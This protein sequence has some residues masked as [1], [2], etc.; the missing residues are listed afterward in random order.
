HIKAGKRIVCWK[1]NASASG[2][3]VKEATTYPDLARLNLARWQMALDRQSPHRIP[4]HT[5]RRYGKESTSF[6]ISRPLNLSQGRRRLSNGWGAIRAI[7][8]QRPIKVIAARAQLHFSSAGA[9]SGR[10]SLPGPSSSAVARGARSV[11][12]WTAPASCCPT[13]SGWG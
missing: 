4:S 9:V 5:A 3:A 2:S 1:L 11:L 12:S 10:E 13:L 6:G 8:F 7:L